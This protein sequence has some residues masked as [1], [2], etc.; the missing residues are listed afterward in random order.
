[1]HG[2][3]RVYVVEPVAELRAQLRQRVKVGRLRDPAR[4]Q[5]VL[6]RKAPPRSALYASTATSPGKLRAT[7]LLSQNRRLARAK[8]SARPIQQG[9]GQWNVRLVRLS[10]YLL[11]QRS[12]SCQGPHLARSRP[13]APPR[14]VST[15][16]LSE[17]TH[18]PPCT[19]AAHI[20]THVGGAL[21]AGTAY[22]LS[23]ACA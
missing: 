6:V 19:P 20:G 14:T 7:S 11:K 5:A 16:P 10:K 22:T 15:G 17:H 12:V 1:M 23:E 8:S 4:E 21:S 2:G 3:R 13:R 18:T 9:T